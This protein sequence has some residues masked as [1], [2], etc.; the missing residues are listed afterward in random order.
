MGIG[1][2]V[3]TMATTANE[4]HEMST[5]RKRNKFVNASPSH[6]RGHKH[7]PKAEWGFTAAYRRATTAMEARCENCETALR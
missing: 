3:T 4:E 1:A 7:K 2:R 5:Q 6:G